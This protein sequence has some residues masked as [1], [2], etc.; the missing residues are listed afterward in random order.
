[1]RK[2][3]L[4]LVLFAAAPAS[5]ESVNFGGTDIAIVLPA[6]YCE[7]QASEKSDVRVLQAIRGMI[8]PIG[9]ALLSDAAECD[10]LQSWRGSKVSPL[11]KMKHYQTYTRAKIDVSS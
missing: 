5:A 11:Q 10:T 2:I 7:L 1:M 9:N 6:G 4:A 3:V 8:E